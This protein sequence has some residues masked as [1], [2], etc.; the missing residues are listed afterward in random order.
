MPPC[1]PSRYGFRLM[2][3]GRENGSVAVASSSVPW[4]VDDKPL[5]FPLGGRCRALGLVEPPP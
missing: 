1:R 4:A 5:E 3:W 2:G